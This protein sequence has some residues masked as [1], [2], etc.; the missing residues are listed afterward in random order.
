MTI[1]MYLGDKIENTSI[2]K[3]AIDYI[4]NNFDIFT[5]SDYIEY[6][7]CKL[8]TFPL[9][10]VDEN[11][12]YKKSYGLN[13]ICRYTCKPISSKGIA[14]TAPLPSP[15]H[16]LQSKNGDNFNS[17]RSIRPAGS[18]ETCDAII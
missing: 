13:T 15:K 10:E 7:V 16:I 4:P 9:V 11:G 5:C 12:L 2:L 3:Y 14:A 1:K 17:S 18:L 6:L 8:L